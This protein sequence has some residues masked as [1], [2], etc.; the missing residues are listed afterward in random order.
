MLTITVNV[1]GNDV[2]AQGSGLTVNRTGTNGSL[3][4]DSAADSKF[5]V[6]DVGS[7]LEI[8]T[9][10]GTQTLTNKSISGD[11]INSG[12]VP[13]AQISEASV[14]QHEAAINHDNLTGFVANEHINWTSTFHDLSTAGS[15]Y[16]GDEIT[17]DTYLLASQYVQSGTVQGGTSVGG[18]L[19]LVTTTDATKGN[20]TIDG[21]AL[22]ITAAADLDAIATNTSKV[23]ADGSVTTH[24]DVTDAGSGSIITSAERTKLSGIEELADV[25]DTAN[26]TAAGAAMLSGQTGGQT[27][28][29][30]TGASENLNLVSTSD[31]TKGNVTIDGI[32]AVTISGTQTLT[33]KSI[34]GDQIN[35]GTI[36]DAQIASSSVTQH[37]GNIAISTFQVSNGT[38]VDARIKETNV[39]QH[40]AAIDHDALTNFVANEHIDWTSTSANLSTTGSATTAAIT[41]S[42][43]DQ[44][45][46]TKTSTD[47]NTIG[48]PLRLVHETTADMVDV[49]GSG[50]E[51]GIKD[52]SGTTNVTSRVQAIRNGADNQTDLRF[53]TGTSG[54]N[55][56]M[57][58]THNGKIGIGT[59]D[60]SGEFH[61][62]NTASGAPISITLDETTND[63]QGRLSSSSTGVVTLSANH[64]AN[65]GI[66]DAKFDF[67]IDNNSHASLTN[68]GVLRITPDS[69]TL[70][71]G[72][73]G[74]HVKDNSTNPNIVVDSGNGAT[75]TPHITIKNDSMNWSSGVDLNDSDKFKIGYAGTAT[76]FTAW[77]NNP[78]LTIDTSDNVTVGADLVVDSGFINMGT[79][80]AVLL[81]STTATITKSRMRIDTLGGTGTLSTLNGGADGDIAIISPVS[82]AKAITVNETGNIVLQGTSFVM[83]DVEYSLSLVYNGT[84]S[85]W[86]ETGRTPITSEAFTEFEGVTISSGS[87]TNY[88]GKAGKC[89]NRSFRCNR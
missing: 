36:P 35:S 84:A 80:G 1:N 46:I 34:S 44:T 61:I 86:Y 73:A 7:E 52:S 89:I 45:L 82:A 48:H 6:G 85:K 32:E 56:R 8:A 57:R 28:T 33:N 50:L 26:V 69:S 12:T 22:T 74:I 39:T 24:N 37:E 75:L 63:V 19:A 72:G 27:L 3:V 67:K 51:F 2:S 11:Q 71:A 31:V 64:G 14:T 15:A 38:F 59:D 78:A 9:I 42:S 79:N 47:T 40:E 83:A 49:F 23:S 70:L 21:H 87:I 54:F 4:Y 65:V 81:T 68:D 10:S 41:S 58:I 55:E 17:T 18:N 13:N 66:T 5:K 77:Y 76:N 60:P 16:F 53:M 25:T 29:G 30:G 88:L 62:A 20:V 43:S